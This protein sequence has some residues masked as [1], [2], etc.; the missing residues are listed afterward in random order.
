MHRTKKAESARKA[1]TGNVG[2]RSSTGRGKREQ[3]E[4]Q[5][6]KTC[7]APSASQTLALKPQPR[8]SDRLNP[9]TIDPFNIQSRV[10]SAFA[11]IYSK[12]GIPCRLVHGSIRHTLQWDSHPATLQFD[13]LLINL[14]EGLKETRHPYTFISQEGFK[15]LLSAEGA[16]QKTLPLLPRLVPVLKSALAHSDDE[17]FRR[18]LNAL[19]QLSAVVGFW[20]NGH[21]KHL[22]SS[23]SKRQM[24]KKFKEQTTEALQKLEQYGGKESL[25]IIKAKIPTYSSIS[26]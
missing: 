24:S 8:P 23:L 3:S 2:Q 25:T 18:G 7:S 14:A 15:E 21:L 20:L 9:K 12:G 11:A 26:S 10:P 6:R 5:E 19:V 22:L 4:S 16:A 17:V 13:P 1:A